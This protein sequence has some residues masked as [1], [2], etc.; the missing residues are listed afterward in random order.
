[1]NDLR[2]DDIWAR[3]TTSTIKQKAVQL[4]TVFFGPM[5]PRHDLLEVLGIRDDEDT[6]VAKEGDDDDVE[7]VGS[8]VQTGTGDK[9]AYNK[10]L[11]RELTGG[12]AGGRRTT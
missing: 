10:R 4:H 2:S 3:V 7:E 8:G 11:V 12:L 6:D 9:Y 5:P 1:M